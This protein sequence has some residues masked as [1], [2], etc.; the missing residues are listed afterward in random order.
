MSGTTKIIGG[1]IVLVA[2]AFGYLIVTLEPSEDSKALVNESKSDN[3]DDAMTSTEAATDDETAMAAATM[4]ESEPT[5]DNAVVNSGENPTLVIAIGGST[6]GTI[7]IELFND[8]APGHVARI[9]Q[10]ANQGKYD[11]VVFHRVIDGFMAQ[12][13]DVEFGVRDGSQTSFAGRGG[14]GMA[15][16]KAEF[17]DEEYVEGIVG[18]ARSNSPDSANSQFFIMFDDAPFLNGQY[19]V[20]GKVIAGLDVVNAIKKGDQNNNGAV[21]DPDYMEKVSVR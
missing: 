14:S 3:S 19:T 13:G 15:D 21:E 12:T 11:N 4:E 10:L 1:I 18:M 6:S 9:V 20:V 2:L 7:E 17:S 5:G 16:L 8:I